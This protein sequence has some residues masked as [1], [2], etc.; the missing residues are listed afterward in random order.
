MLRRALKGE[1]ASWGRG[2]EPWPRKWGPATEAR[3][4]DRSVAGPCSLRALAKAELSMFEGMVWRR[5]GPSSSSLSLDA[6]GWLVD[7]GAHPPRPCVRLV[8]DASCATPGP[9]PSAPL[10]RRLSL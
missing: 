9:R 8:Y 4:Q 1:A 5:H 10:P 6:M 3:E 2:A 7:G